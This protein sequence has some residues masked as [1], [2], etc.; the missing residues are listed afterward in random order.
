VITSVN[1]G[2]YLPECQPHSR[3]GATIAPRDDRF[4]AW[5]AIAHVSKGKHRANGRGINITS[6]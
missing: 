4:M 1:T 5:F 3:N 2:L 6:L